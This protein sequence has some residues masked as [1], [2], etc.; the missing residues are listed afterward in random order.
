VNNKEGLGFTSLEQL[1]GFQKILDEVKRLPAAQEDLINQALAGEAKIVKARSENLD[2]YFDEYS[3]KLDQIANKH[4][5][6]YKSFSTL[7]DK[8]TKNYEAL[9]S[10]IKQL[11]K[12]LDDTA[13]SAN[14]NKKASKTTEEHA[15]NPKSTTKSSADNSSK[16]LTSAIRE[17]I[18]A[19]RRGDEFAATTTG[20]VKKADKSSKRKK[21]STTADG[22]T[23]TP[24]VSTTPSDTLTT[25]QR[26]KMGPLELT[27]QADLIKE[28]EE[29]LKTLSDK[30]HELEERLIFARH[31][32]ELGYI[33]RVE[34]LKSNSIAEAQ[35]A[36]LAAIDKINELRAQQLFA[37]TPES[38][39]LRASEV[40]SKDQEK[41]AE[42]LAKRK[43]AYIA[44]QELIE[45]SKHNG[46]L[47]KDAAARI[48]KE[49]ALKFAAEQKNL[50]K[51]TKER[52]KLERKQQ[53]AED[54]KE[55]TSAVAKLSAENNLIDRFKALSRATEDKVSGDEGGV[56]GAVKKSVAALDTTIV[57]LSEL[58]KQLEDQ[59]DKIAEKQGA[60]DTRLQG[61]NNEKHRGSYWGQLTRDMMS[62]GAVTP[63]FKQEDFSKNIETLVDKGIAFDLKQRAFLMTIQEKIANTFNVADGT[64]LRLIRLQQEDSTA[65][66]L[67]MESALNSFLNNMYE[68]TEYLKDVAAQVRGSLE[69]M[70]ALMKGADATEVEYQV[71]KWMGSLYSV[72]MS[73]TAVQGIASALGQVAAGQIEGLTGGNGA[74]NLLVMAANNAGI[75]IADILAK[76]LD[77][78]DTNKLLQ[79]TVNYLAEIAESSKDNN[80]VQQQLAGVFGVKASDLRAAVNLAEPGTTNDVFGEYRTYD[81]MLYQLS[82]MANT[83]GQ[84]T[85][86]GEMMTNVW[87]NAQYSIASGMANSPIA[88]LTYKLAGLLDSAVGGMPIPHISAFGTGID[89]HTTV[90]DLMRVG[91]VGGSL[92]SNLGPMISGLSSSFDGQSMLARMGIG[93]GAS[94]AITPRG[95]GG[96]V[97]ALDNSGGGQQTMSGSGYVGNNSGSD[98]KNSTLQEAESS[99]K[100]QMIE[101]LEEEPTNQVDMINS[102]VLKI[103]ELL[104]NVANGKQTLRVRVDSYGLTG[105]N[106]TN[107]LGGVTGLSGSSNNSSVSSGG[108]IANGSGSNSFGSGES[109]RNGI[110]GGSVDLG[111]WT[112]M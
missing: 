86:I 32:Q 5:S 18:A 98:I 4:S 106:N 34:E 23:P 37:Q 21:G 24:K 62:V 33:K 97:G 51:I 9:S 50:D 78:E 13:K 90:A 66:R 84:R 101:A 22:A 99:K 94:L 85:S 103:Y 39:E 73:Q 72:G 3:K 102:S 82:A 14:A 52:T 108:S 17:L 25:E 57:A 70:E 109:G 28:R 89:L 95:D 2:I 42:E 79:A 112:M 49:A 27:S 107:A 81:N 15:K 41:S 74:G 12:K 29:R 1:H 40:S 7:D 53:Y 105:A 19:T 77:A 44:K 58:S 93:S 75:P 10:D 92:L 96:G 54:R 67:G 43:A 36:D 11:S 8:L 80:V 38:G 65:G 56:K 71:Q 59:V 110:S 69:E 30:Q 20:S 60:I 31:E 91:A 46:K 45:K 48:Q 16:E 55:T 6:L 100:Q 83:M 111:G 88:Y 68:N 47:D 63:F 26:E 104:D 61:S 76:G 64:L 35:K 87:K